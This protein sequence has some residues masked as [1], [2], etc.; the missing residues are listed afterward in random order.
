MSLIGREVAPLYGCDRARTSV[1]ALKNYFIHSFE[2][3]DS[4][5]QIVG[6]VLHNQGGICLD[7]F[8]QFAQKQCC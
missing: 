7:K 1:P 5:G 2:G 3:I 4:F 6:R 8:P